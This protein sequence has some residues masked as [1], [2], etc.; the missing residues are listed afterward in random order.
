MKAII[1]LVFLSFVCQIQS[2]P[3]GKTKDY[4]IRIQSNF[5]IETFDIKGAAIKEVESNA[6]QPVSF[7]PAPVPVPTLAP[8]TARPNS[9]VQAN[10]TDPEEPEEV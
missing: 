7:S 2:A 10:K 6:T 9:P 3:E 8:A 4:V 1:A 5:E